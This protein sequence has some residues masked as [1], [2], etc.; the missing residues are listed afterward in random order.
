MLYGWNGIQW[1]AVTELCEPEPVARIDPEQRVFQIAVCYFGRMG[2]FA[3]GP[4]RRLY[5]PLVLRH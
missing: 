1:Q 2:L 4:F 5:L 3:P